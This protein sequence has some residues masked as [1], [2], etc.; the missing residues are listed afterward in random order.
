MTRFMPARRVVTAFHCLEFD[1]QALVH[2]QVYTSLADGVTLLGRGNRERGGPRP[3][4]PERGQPVGVLG[5]L[6]GEPSSVS[7]GT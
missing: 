2:E 1:N 6:Q 5:H 7:S 3:R 4:A